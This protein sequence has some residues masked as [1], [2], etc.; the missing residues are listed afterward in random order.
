MV[1]GEAANL[2]FD[3][4][5]VGDGEDSSREGFKADTAQAADADE[6]VVVLES[7][8]VAGAEDSVCKN[9]EV[10]EDIGDG[11]LGGEGKSAA[12]KS[13]GGKEA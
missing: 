3:E 2:L 7:D 10:A 8:A 11:A 4:L 5:F 9:F 6:A 12:D 1:V 13:E